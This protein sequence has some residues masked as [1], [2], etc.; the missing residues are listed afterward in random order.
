MPRHSAGVKS[1]S[2]AAKMKISGAGLPAWTS[3][4]LAMASKG[5][6]LHFSKKRPILLAEAKAI[7]IL[8]SRNSVNKERIPG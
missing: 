1:I 3:A 4:G 5:R 8:A 2:F 6:Q 7:L